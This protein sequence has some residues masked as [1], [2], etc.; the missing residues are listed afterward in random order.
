MTDDVRW[1]GALNYHNAVYDAIAT[2]ALRASLGL[3]RYY[4]NQADH[5]LSLA[6]YDA[7]TL[8]V[9]DLPQVERHEPIRMWLERVGLLVATGTLAER[10]YLLA[11]RRLEMTQS[12]KTTPEQRQRLRACFTARDSPLDI[13][14]LAVLDHLET[15]EAELAA[16]RR[17]ESED[18]DDV[19]FGKIYVQGPE[20]R[21]WFIRRGITSA[22]GPTLTEA[23]ADYDA[24][25]SQL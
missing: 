25:K 21:E 1:W 23:L 17:V 24:K 18:F 16:L 5:D 6:T 19:R 3:F 15:A 10:L 13:A 9:A 22:C 11:R 14:V 12:P 7:F 20:L 8:L 2:R 4:A